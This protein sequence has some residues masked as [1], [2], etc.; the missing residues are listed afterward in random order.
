MT[1]TALRFHRKGPGHY[2]SH[3]GRWM[4]GHMEASDSWHV[5]EDDDEYPTFG[6]RFATKRD[7]VA[8]IR[9]TLE[10]ERTTKDVI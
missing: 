7:A 8:E 9:A 4:V 5:W 10:D 2:Q 6:Q 3:D 1:D